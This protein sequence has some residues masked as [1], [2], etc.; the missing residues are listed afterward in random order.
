MTTVNTRS[1]TAFAPLA[2]E[3]NYE[4]DKNYLFDLSYLTAIDVVG[5]KALEFLQGQLSCDVRKVTQTSMQQGALCNLKGRVLALLDLVK[6]SNQGVYLILPHD[7]MAETQANL[8]KTAI[9][10]RVQLNPMV[11][12]QLFGFY[13]QNQ[14]DL[15]PFNIDL[16][17]NRHDVTYQDSYCCYSLG[18]HRY[19]LLVESKYTEEISAPFKKHLQWRG[20]LAWHAIQLKQQ[21]IEI[22]PKSRGLF[23][24]HRLG[25]H[26][27][28]RL[29]FDKGCYKGQEIIARTHYRATLKHELKV[30]KIETKIMLQ[31]GQALFAANS[32]VEIG[33][34]IDYC[35]LGDNKFLVAAS[36]LIEHPESARIEGHRIDL[37]EE[38][39]TR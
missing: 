38:L 6:W 23:L 7:L 33:E 39:A 37:T 28:G 16:P 12:Y 19:I 18:N 17:E 8:A 34:L 9:F 14:E 26:L 22:Y 10:S 35:P 1:L 32:D 30:F 11:N 25:L 31:S 29:S 20:S 27:S 5:E 15:I 24:P 13:L 4:S 2:H 21:Q 36:L 3:M